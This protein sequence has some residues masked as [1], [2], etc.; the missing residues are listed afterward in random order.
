MISLHNNRRHKEKGITTEAVIEIS[1]ASKRYWEEIKI[2]R[3]A[4]RDPDK[5][6]KI[7]KEKQEEYERAEDSE[8]IEKLFQKLRCSSLCYFQ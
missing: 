5:L 2:L 8:D 7:L 1:L 3:D 4:P 6:R